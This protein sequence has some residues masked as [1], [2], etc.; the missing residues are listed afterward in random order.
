MLSYNNYPY[1]GFSPQKLDRKYYVG[2]NSKLIN[3]IISVILKGFYLSSSFKIIF[4]YRLTFWMFSFLCIKFAKLNGFNSSLFADMYSDFKTIMFTDDTHFH[5]W[6]QM[7]LPFAIVTVTRLSHLGR[8]RF[9][10]RFGVEAIHFGIMT[11]NKG[12]R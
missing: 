3:F 1:S 2:V 7:L 5:S 6:W 4:Y 9:S 10:F 11:Y 12:F 8:T